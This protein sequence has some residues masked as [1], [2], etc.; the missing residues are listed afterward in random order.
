MAPSSPTGLSS[1]HL[2]AQSMCSL[3]WGGGVQNDPD[4]MTGPECQGKGDMWPSTLGASATHLTGRNHPGRVQLLT[5]VTQLSHLGAELGLREP[6]QTPLASLLPTTPSSP[7]K[8]LG[9]ILALPEPRPWASATPTLKEPPRAWGSR[10]A[11]VQRIPEPA[12]P[13]LQVEWSNIVPNRGPMPCPPCP[14]PT[15]SPGFQVSAARGSSGSFY[16]LASRP[17]LLPF[18]SRAS[19]HWTQDTEPRGLERAAS[20]WASHKCRFHCAVGWT[21]RDLTAH[22]YE[23][24]LTG[25]QGLWR[26]DPVKINWPPCGYVGNWTRRGKSAF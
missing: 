18:G 2:S 22:T 8:P 12:V 15:L 20:P 21:A 13:G 19:S 16:S 1:R 25:K 26:R 4:A 3:G 24:E 14:Q 7:K 9:P 11:V 23:C 5:K 17:P 10:L 6:V